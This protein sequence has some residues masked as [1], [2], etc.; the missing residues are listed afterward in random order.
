MITT[1]KAAPYTRQYNVE[2]AHSLNFFA[3]DYPLDYTMQNLLAETLAELLEAAIKGD[4]QID[5][6]IDLYEILD[7]AVD[8]CMPIYYSDILKQW[9][10]AGC[11]DPE[12]MG[13]SSTDNP[14]TIWQLMTRAVWEA[15]Y[16]FAGGLLYTSNDDLAEA[17]ER[18]NTIFP[19]I[20][21]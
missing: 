6:Y 7:N 2:Q 4:R 5:L 18:V 17:L 20:T 14:S 3:S 8:Q 19:L 16:D 10:E 13:A 15:M 12:D 9:Q 11:P 1:H 21:E